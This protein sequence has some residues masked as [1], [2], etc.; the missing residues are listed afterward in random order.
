MDEEVSDEALSTTTFFGFG[1]ATGV[2]AIFMA[3]DFSVS[4]ARMPIDIL[5]A[6]G[7]GCLIDKG[8]IVVAQLECVE[9]VLSAMLFS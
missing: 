8:W 6:C 1:G 9:R 3:S 7:C 4:A 5:N 2:L